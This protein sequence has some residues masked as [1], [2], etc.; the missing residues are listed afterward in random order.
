MGDVRQ[1]LRLLVRGPLLSGTV[2]AILSLA[3]GAGTAIF[4]IVHA[5][6]LAPLPTPDPDRVLSVWEAN[7]AADNALH[8][9]STHN[10]ASWAQ[11]SRQV[12]S[13]GVWRDWGMRL[14]LADGP[15]PL[16]GAIAS[17]G[18]FRVLRTVPAQG[19]VLTD[20]DGA[21][22]R[23]SVVVL[24]Y[25]TWR[26]RFGGDP[27]IVGRSITLSRS[28]D[29]PRPF[30]IVGV[31]PPDVLPSMD[32]VELWAPATLDPD[33]REGRW[34]RNR[35]VIARLAP[36]ASIDSARAELSG[37][38][39]ALAR[40][41]PDSNR[42]WGV[43]LMPIAD[44]EL[45]PVRAPLTMFGV[46]IGFLLLIACAN[47]AG[48]LV[49]R[50]TGRGRELGIRLAL[51]ARRSRIV[52]MLLVESVVLALPGALGGAL[53]AGWLVSLF[54][55]YGPL[56][57]RSTAIEVD[58]AALV[59]AIAVS[60]ATGMLFGLAPALQSAAVSAA[61]SLKDARAFLRMPGMRL[62]SALVTTEVA[63]AIVLVVGAGLAIRSF[64]ATLATPLGI[65]PHDVIV[66]QVFPPSAKYGDDARLQSAYRE[67][68]DRLRAVPGVGSVGAASAGPLFGGVEV[69]EFAI[70]GAPPSSGTDAPRARYFD[71]APGYFETM[72]M[73]VVAGRGIGRDDASGAPPVAVVNGAFARRWFPSGAVGRRIRIAHDDRGPLQIVGVVND[74][75]QALAPGTPI[76]PAIYW[77]AAQYVRGAIYFVVR[78]S[79]DPQRVIAPIRSTL[80]GMDRDLVPSRITTLEQ[81]IERSARRPRFNGLLLG[82]FAAIALVLAMV[83]VYGLTAY[84]VGQRTREIGLRISL[85]ATAADVL[86]LVL[87][88]GVRAAAIG[89]IAGLAGA[90]LLAR[91]M[92]SLV[93]GIEP[94]DPVAFGAAA[95]LLAAVAAAAMILPAR[96]AMRVDPALA[97]RSD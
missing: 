41:F 70:E 10:V 27:A 40:E 86:R 80:A 61:E 67:I 23:N 79:I 85:G 6:L 88:D 22:G 25:T 75:R 93:V 11:A 71:A 18:F 29:G 58:A 92:R 76:E 54:K 15:Q 69:T 82:L 7:P 84:A 65:D 36:G 30:T 4:T 81:L 34:L 60:L 5:V 38:A 83:G 1:A 49:A 96:R 46:A 43:D 66:F 62:R 8:I 78:T 42:G 31:M 59:F 53:T 57:P 37:I 45:G 50:A 68:A 72:G 20:A 94:L 26:D 19:R 97:L 21:P 90:M 63:L 64:A 12:E 28:P 39:A 33:L 9:A 51:G 91:A 14:Q 13:F 52:R 95:L 74:T 17:P 77:P 3:I 55:A 73:T 2:V 44:A 87:G 89:G 32:G 48:L 16:V 35:R 47:V 24:A 56:L